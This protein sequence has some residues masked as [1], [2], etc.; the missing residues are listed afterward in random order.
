MN[1]SS[2]ENKAKKVLNKQELFQWLSVG[3]LCLFVIEALLLPFVISS[4]YAK[5]EVE[6]NRMLIYERNELVWG[7]DADVDEN[8]SA[9]LSLFDASYDNVA[10]VDGAN[11]IAPGTEGTD[12]VQLKNKV[13]GNVTYTAVL[14]VIK[15]DGKLPVDASLEGE[16]FTDTESYVLPEGVEEAQVIR[17]VTGDIEKNEIV[18][19]DVTWLWQYEEGAE[20]DVIDTVLGNK[21]EADD[22]TLGLHITVEDDNIYVTPTA[23]IILYSS[24]MAVSLGGLTTVGI[25]WLKEKKKSEKKD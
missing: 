21:A 15:D 25:F 16:A 19:F 13:S 24:L 1:N 6:P 20:Q 5:K 2:S 8:G 23:T 3:A 4:I 9:V 14:Y 17:A 10:S 7:D 22:V 12:T 18:N 11:V